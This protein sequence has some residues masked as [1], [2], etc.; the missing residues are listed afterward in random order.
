MERDR[1]GYRLS[2]GGCLLTLVAFVLAITATIS[3]SWATFIGSMTGHFG[4]WKVCQ[5]DPYP[6]CRTHGSRMQTTWASQVAGAGSAAC[7]CLLGL[8]LFMCPLL[9]AM[10]VTATKTLVKFRHATLVKMV[11][12]ATSA[13][14][15]LMSVL[16]FLLEVF[17]F[18][19]GDQSG[20]IVSL[21]WAFYLQLLALLVGM[22]AGA[23]A[24]VE[25]G[26]ARK[27]GGDPTVYRRDPE[28]IAATTISNPY[29][30][31]PRNGH[32]QGNSHGR[33]GRTRSS[34]R[35]G[36]GLHQNSNGVKMT[37]L[38]GQ[39][40]MVTGNGTNGHISHRNGVVAFDP[41]RAPGRSSLR[42]PKPQ[43]SEDTTDSSMGIENLAFKQSS[44]TPK[45]KVRIHTQSTPV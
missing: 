1:R 25:F 37:G 42:R 8:A 29:V 40:Y 20:L 31:E 41:N 9:V 5:N 28:G 38:S 13:L 32:A 3:N 2:L 11:C 6:T 39:P 22:I 33:Q 21:S 45:K 44:P 10:H 35:G 27:L 15:A 16:F 43:P 4:P 17:V 36:G 14:C 24:G 30:V 19:V 7:T 12:T 18:R 23:G 26:W 34:G